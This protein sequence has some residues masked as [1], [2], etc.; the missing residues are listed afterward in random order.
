M[1]NQLIGKH[2]EDLAVSFL[3]NHGFEV[4]ERN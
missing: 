1:D 3:E 2:G 4:I